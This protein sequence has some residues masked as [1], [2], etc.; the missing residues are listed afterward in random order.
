MLQIRS[1]LKVDKITGALNGHCV[2]LAVDKI[3]VDGRH[4][5]QAIDRL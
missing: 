1:V 2:N 3:C 5:I 4:S